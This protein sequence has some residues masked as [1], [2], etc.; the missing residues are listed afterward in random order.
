[1]NLSTRHTSAQD[2]YPFDSLEPGR[3]YSSDNYRFGFNGKENDNEVKGTGNSVDFGA[4]IYDSRLGRWMA[5][6]PKRAK[7]PDI[8]P[9]VFGANS[10]VVAIDPNG[11][12]I[13]ITTETNKETG[14]TTITVTISG[15]V[16][17]DHLNNPTN[18]TT[19]QN[20]VNNLNEALTSTYS[21]AFGDVEVVFV[22][23]FVLGTDEDILP[24]D[25]VV[26]VTNLHSDS[27]TKIPKDKVSG[28]A[29][30]YGGKAAYF[31][32]S[33]SFHTPTHEI[34]HLL[35]LLHPFELIGYFQKYPETVQLA[36]PGLT[37]DFLDNNMSWDNIMEYYTDD[38]TRGGWNFDKYQLYAMLLL[39]DMNMLNQGTNEY[40]KTYC[41]KNGAACMN[42][43][44]TV[45]KK[46]LD[47][48]TKKEEPKTDE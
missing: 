19:R 2:Y 1:M 16:S 43:A 29:N 7:Y 35:G 23:K 12:E 18:S 6:D 46:M 42:A 14:K 30:F 36:F 15:V 21:K 5:C 3:T 13:V 31:P 22:S 34:G 10:P 24:E 4:R 41:T 48:E 44:F 25:H 38:G 39:Y 26:Y 33:L 28:F 37:M 27:E 32:K 47:E 11:E 20:Y 40:T 8:S 17:F 45:F 9:Y